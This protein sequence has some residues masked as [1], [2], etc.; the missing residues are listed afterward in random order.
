MQRAGS[1]MSQQLSGAFR[2]ALS[3]TGRSGRCFLLMDQGGTNVRLSVYAAGRRWAW[4]Q[5]AWSNGQGAE[6][7]C[8][9]VRSSQQ[10]YALLAE[11]AAALNL[12]AADA[13]QIRAVLAFAGA[14]SADRDS[15]P[16]TNWPEQPILTLAG[17]ERALCG[18]PVLMLNDV[19]AAAF[20]LVALEAQ[21]AWPE[22]AC[23][24][25]VDGI[26]H[27]RLRAGS[28]ERLAQN[29]AIVVPGTGVGTGFIVSVPRL[30]GGKRADLPEVVPCE[31]QHSPIAAQTPEEFALIEWLRRHRTEGC[32]P[33][34]ESIV[35]GD[36]LENVYDFLVQSAGGLEAACR[37]CPEVET[38]SVRAAAIA[39]AAQSDPPDPTC[40]EALSIY[41][42]F[43]GRLAQTLAL[44]VKAFGGI[45][46]AGD[47]TSRNWT[48][49]PG[50][51]YVRNFLTNHK[52]AVLLQDCPLYLLDKPGLNLDGALYAA[53]YRW[54]LRPQN[55]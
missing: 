30:A 35:S 48:F 47:T 37:A 25:G 51:P 14:V 2:Q 19:E 33:C 9:D 46:L 23:E 26:R 31:V 39:Q 3:E 15:V 12:S 4:P 8:S 17:L 29:R 18:A 42:A 7:R 16:I 20:G 6:L 45:Y 22:R 27:I 34:F 24:I 32:P 40:R 38:A 28:R 10:L 54:Y 13:P 49:L 21:N 43:C 55:R 11:V 53:C 52:Q 50:S 41:Y 5:R 44:A 1:N 36:G